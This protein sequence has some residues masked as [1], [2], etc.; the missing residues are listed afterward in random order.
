MVLFTL[1]FTFGVWLLQQQAALPD[2]V[3][4]K[5][6]LV[7]PLL[8]LFLTLRAPALNRFANFARSLLR[9]V[10]IAVFAGGLGFYH[11][12]YQA[13]QRLS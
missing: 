13:Q 10:L 4:A 3:W 8:W 1:S 6:L 2:F 12:A 9:L 11:A 7:A 5:L